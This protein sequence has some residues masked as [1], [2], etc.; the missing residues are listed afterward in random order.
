MNRRSLL[1]GLVA[2]TMTPRTPD[3]LATAP[4]DWPP[5]ETLRLWPSDAPGR[6]G[7]RAPT[8]PVDQPAEFLRAIEVPTLNVF[9]APTPDGRALLVCPGGAYLFV[10]IANEGV[11]VARVFNPLGITVFVLAYRLPCEGWANRAD[12]PLQDAQRAMRLI[13]ANAGHFAIDPER[14]SVLGF[15]AGGHLAASLVTG[16]DEV[17]YAPVDD[18]DTYAARPASAGLIYPV[19]TLTMPHA[20][21]GSRDNLL[22]VDAPPALVAQRSP[23]LNVRDNTPP[24]FIAHAEDDGVVPIANAERMKAALDAKGVRAQFVRY[25]QGDHAFGVGRPGTGTGSWPRLF[26][27]FNDV[28]DRR[29]FENERR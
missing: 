26:C 11:D 1:Q 20:H 9:R 5:P 27:E 6:A 15:S 18:A 25:A 12:V 4:R 10:S 14:L 17:V 13:R 21:T 19:I 29:A 22:G 28:G 2:L 23:E 7:Y 3:A 8:L 24:C 16:W